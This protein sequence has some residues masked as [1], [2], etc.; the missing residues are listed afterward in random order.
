MLAELPTG[1]RSQ[2]VDDAVSAFR[3]ALVIRTVDRD[4]AGRMRTLR[5]LATIYPEW[6]RPDSPGEAEQLAAEAA[7]EADAIQAG[8]PRATAASASWG[9]FTGRMSALT[10]DLARF[11]GVPEET[12]A[13]SLAATVVDHRSALAMIGREQM[14]VEW[15]RWTGGLARLRSCHAI[16]LGVEDALADSFA[17]F[18]DALAAVER[19]D[20]PRLWRDLRRALGEAAHLCGAWERSYIAHA[21]VVDVGDELVAATSGWDERATELEAVRGAAICAVYA[22]VK[23]QRR[24]EAVTM[25]ERALARRLADVLL[26]AETAREAP[27]GEARERLRA[28]R[29][30]VLDLEQQIRAEPEDELSSMR[31]RLADALGCDASLIGMTVKERRSVPDSGVDDRRRELDGR[32]AAARQALRE[33]IGRELGVADLPAAIGADAVKQVAASNGVPIVY[34]VPSM[35]GCAAVAV[36]P[37]GVMPTLQ[38]DGLTSGHLPPCSTAVRASRRSGRIST[39]AVLRTRSLCSKR[40]FRRPSGC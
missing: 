23:T 20:Q 35:H 13:E 12:V 32:L 18:D 14:P 38:L 37:D 22:A 30:L 31:N 8:S 6:T 33:E 34:L 7:R 19:R 2:H 25:A 21:A 36:L 17:L 26:A 27:S 29:K 11:D 24:D 10:L 28:A 1:V 4:P 9:A 16:F 40:Y 3:Q 15:A 39:A 5:A